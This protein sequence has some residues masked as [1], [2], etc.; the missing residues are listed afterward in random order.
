VRRLLRGLATLVIFVVGLFFLV[1]ALGGHLQLLD[2][3]KLMAE[4]KSAEGTIIGARSGGKKSASYYFSYE[5][6]AGGVLHARKDV[7]VSYS[8]YQ[9]LRAGSRI[10]VRYDPG[11]PAKNVTTPEMAEFESIPNRLFLPGVALVLLG[12]WVARIVRKRP[13]PPTPPVSP[14]TPERVRYVNPVRRGE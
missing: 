1:L 3:R 2:A 13:A 14:A 11:N 9:K 4:G 8:D 5:F 12:W 7:G 6:P 10:L